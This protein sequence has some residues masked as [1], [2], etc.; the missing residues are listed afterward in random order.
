MT[1]S[2]LVVELGRQCGAR[3]EEMAEVLDDRSVGLHR[4]VSPGRRVTAQIWEEIGVRGRGRCGA[5]SH[6]RCEKFPCTFE[7]QPLGVAC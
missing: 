5:G 1:D 3:A 2:K 6:I 4:E 7:N